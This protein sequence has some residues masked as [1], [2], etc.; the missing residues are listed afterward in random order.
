[1]TTANFPQV[2]DK[3]VDLRAPAAAHKFGRC[4]DV[5]TVSRITQTLVITSDGERY[6]RERL[7]P[8]SEGRYSDRQ[9]VPFG[10]PRVLVVLGRE[11]LVGVAK[12]ADNIA[13]LDHKAPEDVLAG[14]A[15]IIMA[16][17]D[18]RRRV[19]EIMRE[20]SKTEQESPR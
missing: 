15:R 8:V 6:N 19:I 17:S 12:L 4:G 3:A 7:H 16:A 14:L 9:L 11:Q 5:V 13:K 10:D 2:G 1:M 20:A 18:A